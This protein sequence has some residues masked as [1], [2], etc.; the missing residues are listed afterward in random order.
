MYLDNAATSHPRP[1][2]VIEAMRRLLAEAGAN[3][4]RGGH[5]LAEAAASVVHDT[6][7]RIARLFRVPDPKGVIF[8]LNATDA[9]N[10][11]IKGIV[12][13][14]DHVVT[15]SMEHNAVIRPLRG[16]E[17]R[18]VKLTVVSADP[19]GFVPP[20]RIAEALSPD[21]R[22]V[23]VTHASNVNGTVEPIEEI[24][25]IC[26]KAGVPL[27]VDAA[28]SA[29]ILPIDLSVLPVD[30]L[31]CSGHKGLMGPP[32]T[33]LLI[34]REATLRLLPLR[35]GGTGTFSEMETQPETLPDALES[36]TMNTPGIAGLGAAL[37]YIEA[38]GAERLMRTHR[39]L[40]DALLESLRGIPG[41]RCL[42]PHDLRLHAP[43][44]SIEIAG[45]DPHEAALA[46]D[47]AYDIQCRAGLHC[48]PLAHRTLGT[49]PQ[50]T[51]RLSPGAFNTPEEIG[52]A[53][54]AIAELAAHP[55]R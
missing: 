51:L 20:S 41:V 31:A 1:P 26:R 35:E 8:T 22:L 53:V 55:P 14:G 44:V 12:S 6:R 28:Q 38:L 3:P 9:L 39:E 19:D 13:P 11:A 17:Q 25:E 24:G 5:R 37:R 49:F 15:T 33:G 21:T 50:G 36:G 54:S 29:G 47:T 45:W 43:V 23:V 48:A 32:G 2:Q 52:M 30:L 18:G 34:V 27:L 40:S 7:V 42:L 46:L 10:I 16:L 4:G